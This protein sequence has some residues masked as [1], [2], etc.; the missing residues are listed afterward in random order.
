[1]AKV[2]PVNVACCVIIVFLMFLF[3]LQFWECL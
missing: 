3:D 2:R 1:M